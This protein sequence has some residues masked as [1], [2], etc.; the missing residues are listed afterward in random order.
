MIR[1]STFSSISPRGWMIVAAGFTLMGLGTGMSFI[2]GVFLKPLAQDF[3]WT[4]S[5]IALAFSLNMLVMGAFSFVMGRMSDRWGAARVLLVGTLIMGV[6]IYLSS[7]ISAA[8]QLYVFFGILMGIGKSAYHTPLMSYIAR[9]FN[10]RRGLAVGLVF[11]GT[12]IGLFV[13]APLARYLITQAGWRNTFVILAV[14]LVVLTLPALWFFREKPGQVVERGEENNGDLPSASAAPITEETPPERF[15]W[16]N[17]SYWTI[18]GLHYFDCVCHSVPLVHVVAYA[19]DRSIS[20]EQ[21][22]SVLGIVGLSAIAG[23][24][25]IPALTDRIGSR[26]GLLVTLLFQTGMIPYLMVSD[27]LTMFYIFAVIFGFGWGGNSPM[28]PLL[29]RDYFGPKRLG[30]IYGGTVV[31]ASLGMAAGGY[32]GGLLFDISGTYQLSLIFSL[33]A[34]L[35]SIALIPFLKPIRRRK[36]R[37]E[38]AVSITPATAVLEI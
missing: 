1:S 4:R 17:R 34:G 18:C 30:T 25:S 20:P 12:G 27:S 9:I 14:G 36:G 10:K 26:N 23:R 15:H 3:G 22:A 33:S 35:I 13:M 21:G 28:Y 31:A 2:I 7:T 11:A 5:E 38:P 6:G 29:A 8:W 32:M 16:K 19:T 37:T 24:V